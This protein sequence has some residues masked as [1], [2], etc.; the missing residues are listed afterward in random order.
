MLEFMNRKSGGEWASLPVAVFYTKDFQELYRYF[1]YPDIY[2][3][4]R[5][6]GHQQAA[7]PG[8][9]PEQAKER[10]GRE[11]AALQVSPFFDLWASAA[12]DQILSALHETMVLARGAASTGASP[13]GRARGLTRGLAAAPVPPL[14]TRLAD[15]PARP[16]ASTPGASNGAIC[17]RFVGPARQTRTRPSSRSFQGRWRPAMAWASL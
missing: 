5:I 8:E 14:R 2:H 15:L 10:S 1:E 6:R 4:D 9:T 17:S 12:I 16:D 11:F 7:R 3:K 13:P